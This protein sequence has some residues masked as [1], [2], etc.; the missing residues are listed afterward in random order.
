[1]ISRFVVLAVNPT[2]ERSVAVSAVRK[3]ITRVVKKLVDDRK[4]ALLRYRI[5]VLTLRPDSTWRRTDQGRRDVRHRERLFP[6][7]RNYDGGGAR[8]L[9]RDFD[10]AQS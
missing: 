9:K 7:I 4:V 3:L 10:V 5:D 6:R 1:M 8:I 2:D